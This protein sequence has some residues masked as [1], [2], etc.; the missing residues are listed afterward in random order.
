AAVGRRAACPT[1][2][3]EI[4]HAG[5][6]SGCAHAV[7]EGYALDSTV[8]QAAAVTT[9]AKQF[10]HIG[11]EGSLPDTTCYE[12][13]MVH[14][15]QLRKT[16]A[17]WTPGLHRVASTEPGQQARE[18]PHHEVYHVHCDGLALGVYGGI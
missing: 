15:H 5:R 7:I 9:L 18:L 1:G 2:R 17:E 3:A 10:A 16:V 6:H 13:D 11:Q 14:S 8:G 4:A 12:T